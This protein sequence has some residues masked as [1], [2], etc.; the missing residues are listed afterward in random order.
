[1]TLDCT[2]PSCDTFTASVGLT[3]AATF[4]IRRSLPGAPTDTVFASV[5]IEFAPS[6]TAPGAIAAAPWPI[7]VA[8]LPD[9]SALAPI[10]VPPSLFALAPLPSA[11]ELACDAI[12]FAPI[13]TA[14]VPVAPVLS[15]FP[16]CEPASFTLT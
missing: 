12:A 13:A 8:L 15:K 16:C 3:P 14:F 11:T 7:A 2:A 4:V 5:A 6:A 1:M 9:T 10:T